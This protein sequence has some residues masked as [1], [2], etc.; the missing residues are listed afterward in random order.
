MFWLIWWGMVVVLTMVWYTVVWR[1]VRRYYTLVGAH[2]SFPFL[3]P[4]FSRREITEEYKVRLARAKIFFFRMWPIAE[5]PVYMIEEGDFIWNASLSVT[6][7]KRC[8][9][10]F[11]ERI[12]RECTDQELAGILAH[13]IG[14]FNDWE[15]CLIKE[16]EPHI[17]ADIRGALLTDRETV[18]AALRWLEKAEK[19]L[20]D[21]HRCLLHF[22]KIFPFLG[23]NLEQRL[24]TLQ[25]R[26]ETLEKMGI[27]YVDHDLRNLRRKGA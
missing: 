21:D 14:H 2:L 26:I 16:D 18:L 25:K 8:L 12:L 15:K 10:S 11:H 13:E 3:C 6:Y 17:L 7:D 1:T 20:I 24:L 5:D 27:Y 4:S 19:E 9:V 23:L 22:L